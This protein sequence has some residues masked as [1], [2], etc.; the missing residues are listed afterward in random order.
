MEDDAHPFPSIFMPGLP[1]K[2]SL[3]DWKQTSCGAGFGES[4]DDTLDLRGSL[5]DDEGK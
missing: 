3:E 2:A 1:R 4:K 5:A